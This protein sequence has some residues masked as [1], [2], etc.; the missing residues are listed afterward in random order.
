MKENLVFIAK[1]SHISKPRAKKNKNTIILV[2]KQRIRINF[3]FQANGK[4][5]I[6]YQTASAAGIRKLK[7]RHFNAIWKPFLFFEFLTGK[8]RK[9]PK[10]IFCQENRCVGINI[11]F[12]WFYR[13]YS[14]FTWNLG[15]TWIVL[16]CNFVP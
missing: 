4:I 9:E 15:Q 7:S 5:L 10:I 12:R 6:A 16:N 11:A 1:I 3:T 13:P 8:I 14:G 2:W